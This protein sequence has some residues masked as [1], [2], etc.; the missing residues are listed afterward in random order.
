MIGTTYHTK[1][2]ELS[3]EKKIV[4]VDVLFRGVG[5]QSLAYQPDK[6]SLNLSR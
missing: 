4:F 1:A 5:V 2:N 6:L 3:E